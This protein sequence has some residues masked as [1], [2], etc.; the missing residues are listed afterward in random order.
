LAANLTGKTAILWCK[1]VLN[2]NLTKKKARLAANGFNIISTKDGHDEELRTL[3]S[4]ISTL[5]G[6]F[7]T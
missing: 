4:C 1:W 2:L 3:I 5:N 6:L 7:V